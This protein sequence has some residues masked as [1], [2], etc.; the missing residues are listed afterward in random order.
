[1]LLVICL[2]LRFFWDVY[3]F[4][5]FLAVGMGHTDGFFR[6]SLRRVYSVLG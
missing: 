6:G 4:V 5:H 2:F 1:M 3:A